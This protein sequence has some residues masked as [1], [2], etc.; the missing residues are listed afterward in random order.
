MI[1]KTLLVVAVLILAVLAFAATRPDSFQ[2]QRTI[3]IQAPAVKVFALVDDFH[4]WNRWAPQDREDATMRRTFAGADRGTGAISNWQGNGSAG[5]GRMEITEAVAPT[6]VTVQTDFVKPPV[7]HNINDFAFE[8]AG[9]QTRVTWTMRGS[10]LYMM[11]VMSLFVNMD[12]MMG[13]HFETGLANLKAEA[14]K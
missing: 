13:K 6:H 7:A 8:P 11:K 5:K 9:D 10:N 2:I 1:L 12:R 3:V 4:Q 14:E